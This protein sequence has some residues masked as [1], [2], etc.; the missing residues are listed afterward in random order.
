MKKYTKKTVIEVIEEHA[1]G[2]VLVQ[3]EG[4]PLDRWVIDAKTFAE[5]YA[6]VKETKRGK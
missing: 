2:S 4:N 3:N 6:Q 5:T 1:D